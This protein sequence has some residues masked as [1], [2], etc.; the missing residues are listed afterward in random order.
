MND[1]LKFLYRNY[2][3]HVDMIE[4][5]KNQGYRIIESSNKGVLITDKD[6]MV[7]MLSV[8]DINSKG[9]FI[10]KIPNEAKMI[11]AHQKF[12]ADY[13]KE[14]FNVVDEMNC[15]QS[16]YTKKAPLIID[17]DN[18][19]IKRLNEEYAEFVFNNYSSKDTADIDYI[20]DRIKS[21]TMLGAFVDEKLV[22]F[23][24]THEEGAIGILEVLPHY[25]NRGIGE[26]LQRCAT[27]LALEQDRIPYGQVKINNIKSIRLQKRLGFE[28]S[29]DIVY[30]LMI[31]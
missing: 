29:E 14:I 1:V 4:C 10:S 20:I 17:N 18:V 15:Y 16:V 31:D 9:D 28:I 12:C 2:L 8:I 27:N 24:G 3:L 26:K 5:I 13:L 30:W 11:V 23:I 21:N 19:K 7:V 25:R 6:N 22:G